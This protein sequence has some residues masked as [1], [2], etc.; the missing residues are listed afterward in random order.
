VSYQVSHNSEKHP[1]KKGKNK[2]IME[3]GS[4]ASERRDQ[5]LLSVVGR[6]HIV[7]RN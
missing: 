7:Q 6:L 3:E 2:E 5:N 4:K 1:Q